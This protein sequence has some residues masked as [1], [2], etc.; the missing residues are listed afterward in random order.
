MALARGVLS[1]VKAQH[2]RGEA[3]S[4]AL[5]L[6]A[7]RPPGW[8]FPLGQKRFVRVE[9]GAPSSGPA[10]QLSYQGSSSCQGVLA[11]T[12]AVPRTGPE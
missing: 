2:L 10:Q 8:C 12:R 3:G 7:E 1:C 6:K 9:L 11:G 5:Q 4:Q